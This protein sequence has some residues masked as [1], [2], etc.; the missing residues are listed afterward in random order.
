MGA[1]VKKRKQLRKKSRNAGKLKF[2]CHATKLSWKKGSNVE[3]NLK[4]I[5]LSYDPNNIKQ[6][7]RKRFNKLKAMYNSSNKNKKV[8]SKS[9]DDASNKDRDDGFVDY[10]PRDLD[11]FINTDDGDK[12][13]EPLLL[14]I[15]P[16][17]LTTQ[18]NIALNTTPSNL[19]TSLP[20]HR[21]E[22]YQRLINKHGRNYHAMYTD[23]PLNYFQLTENRI[24]K[25]IQ[26]FRYEFKFR[27]QKAVVKL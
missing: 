26:H 22:Y 21:R 19:F 18:L 3:K 8:A 9:N 20:R 14:N 5:G 4:I 13:K 16:S 6:E 12:D 10:H 25:D 17:A 1:N 15:P 7:R 11:A 2:K 24:R 23:I 27:P